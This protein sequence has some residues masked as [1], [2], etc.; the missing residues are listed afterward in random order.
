MYQELWLGTLAF[1]MILAAFYLTAIFLQQYKEQK[2]SELSIAIVCVGFE[3]S[4][5]AHDTLQ[6]VDKEVA[7]SKRTTYYNEIQAGRDVTDAIE[8]YDGLYRS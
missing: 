2:S 7:Y 3:L 5:N 4:Y 1:G 8:K 6:K